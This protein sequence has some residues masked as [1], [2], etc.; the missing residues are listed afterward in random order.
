MLKFFVCLF[1]AKI[2][3]PATSRFFP[4]L[5]F[6]V[7]VVTFIPTFKLESTGMGCQ[8]KI[9]ERNKE[10]D[11]PDYPPPGKNKKKN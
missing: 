3:M 8:T 10:K 11:K 9:T 7:V 5:F 4:R 1:F 2:E 6:V